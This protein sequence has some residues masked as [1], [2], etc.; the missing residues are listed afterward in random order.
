MVLE[1]HWKF[2]IGVLEN[3]EVVMVGIMDAPAV[4]V[5]IYLRRWLVNCCRPLESVLSNGWLARCSLTIKK[6]SRINHFM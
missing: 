2:I 6:S 3:Y 5:I 4:Q 1:A